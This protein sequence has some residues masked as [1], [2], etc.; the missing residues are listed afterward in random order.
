MKVVVQNAYLALTALLIRLVSGTNAQIH[1][2]V[3]VGQMRSAPL[4]IMFP[5]VLVL[6]AIQATRLH[7]VSE[8]NHLKRLDHVNHHHVVLI[9][10]AGKMVG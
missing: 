9:V 1:A 10:Y 2:Q 7:N 4:L 3:F 8:K 6:K 5:V